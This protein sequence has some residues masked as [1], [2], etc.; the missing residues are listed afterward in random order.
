MP[1]RPVC[2]MTVTELRRPRKRRRAQILRGLRECRPI[3]A[4]QIDLARPGC[5]LP[6][7]ERGVAVLGRAGA[8]ASRCYAKGT[9]RN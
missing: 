8:K 1:H 7:R 6:R 3:V 9:A 2:T 4:G 5:E